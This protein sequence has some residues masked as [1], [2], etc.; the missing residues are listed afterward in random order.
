M[1]RLA[2]FALAMAPQLIA[3]RR[4]AA[5]HHASQRNANQEN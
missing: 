3:T 2:A 1:I 4:S 5:Q